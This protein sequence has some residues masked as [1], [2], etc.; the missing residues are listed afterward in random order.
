MHTT[1]NYIYHLIAILTVGIWGLTFISTKVLIEHGLSPQEI[2]L[3]RFLM[4]YL[5]IWFIS[6]RK[7]F[8]DNWKD[9]LWLMAGGFFGGSLYF[10]T[11][12]TALGITQASN[13]AFIIC[14]APLLTTILSLL[15]YKKEK[16]TAGLVGGSLL[17]LVGVALVVYNGHF[18]L[19]ISPLGDFL[20]LL[21]AFSWA[22]YS[23]IMKKMSGRYR[24]TFITRKIF[25][26]GILTILP[27]FILHPWQFS[28]SGLWQ[29]AVWMNLLF[30]GVLASL[31]CFVVWN[32]ILKQLGTVRASNY[33]Y[34]NPLFTLIGSAVL[35]DEQFTVMSLMGA[36]LILGGVYWAGKR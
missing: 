23:L 3:L 15:I 10:F 19:K 18:I 27:A 21:A 36:M 14:T 31:V 12:N 29:P 22:F 16:A 28:L 30:L 24:T 35:L 25:F 5:G 7:L 6:P 2:F 32:I 26:Y 8:A 9:E 20:T 11:E 1:K 4:A 17:A 13:V 34:L 33:I